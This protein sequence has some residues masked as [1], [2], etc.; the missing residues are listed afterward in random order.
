M[1]KTILDIVR[2]S[3]LTYNWYISD[4]QS[5]DSIQVSPIV[6]IMAFITKEA[7]PESR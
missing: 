6:S 4:V 2:I 7:S 3:E 1:L 5:S